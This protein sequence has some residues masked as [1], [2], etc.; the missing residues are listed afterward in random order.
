MIFADG[1]FIL[2]QS[3]IILIL[4]GKYGD[5]SMLRIILGLLASFGLMY[6]FMFGLAPEKLYAANQVILLSLGKQRRKKMFP[7]IRKISIFFIF[8]RIFTIFLV[9]LNLS[10]HFRE[11]QP[12][13]FEHQKQEHGRAEPVYSVPKIRWKRR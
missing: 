10:R 1:F 4:I 11:G 9:K 5:I 8:F 3:W 2:A 13:F 6:V 7:K 12:D